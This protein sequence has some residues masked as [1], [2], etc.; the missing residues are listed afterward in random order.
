MRAMVSRM[1]LFGFCF[2]LGVS[3]CGS[4]VASNARAA[5]A[6]AATAEAPQATINVTA[7]AEAPV[8]LE[9]AP[10]RT[11]LYDYVERPEPKYSWKLVKKSANPQGGKNWQL[12]MVSQ[13]WQGILWEHDLQVFEPKELK[14]PDKL[15]IYNTGGQANPADALLGTLLC[16]KTGSRVAVLYGVPNQPLF[17]DLREDDLIAH[18]YVKYLETHDATWPLLFPMAKSMVKAM[19]TVQA[20]G[21]EEAWQPNVEKYLPT[22]GSKR[23]W[24][25]WLA[26]ITDPR[27]FAV[28]PIV[29]EINMREQMANQLRVLGTNTYKLKPYA[30][31]GL[32]DPAKFDTPEGRRLWQWV[33]PWMYRDRLQMPKLLIKATNDPWW[34]VES[35]NLYWDDL[36][37]PKH[38]LYF[39]NEVHELPGHRPQAAAAVAAFFRQAA[40]GQTLPDITWLH[41]D[42]GE[43]L[44]LSVTASVKPHTVK[45]WRATSDSLDFRESKWESEVMPPEGN[46]YVGTLPRPTAGH[47]ALFGE[48]EF[49]LDDLK[50]SLSTQ[51]R[52]Q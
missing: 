19:D 48:L 22:G 4:P 3:C 43:A 7:T 28:A 23:G 39:T 44:K 34:L 18:S 5:D 40:T 11:P 20:L 17:G 37:G 8:N 16:E 27:V 47:V 41:E 24:T 38:L 49:Y 2:G 6:P 9:A 12:H 15:V 29:I 33:D 52:V 36:Q 30:S 46:A 42:A 26:A 31:R 1:V 10:A 51:I 35:A 45:L 13:E 14:F 25:S 21:K 50:Y 32:S